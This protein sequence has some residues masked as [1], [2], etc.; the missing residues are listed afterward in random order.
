MNL[1]QARKVDLSFGGPLL[2]DKADLFIDTAE[3]IALIGRNGVG[4]S[5]LLKVIQ[6]TIRPDGGEVIY[7]PHLKLASLEQKIPEDITGAVFDVVAAGLGEV[8]GLLLKYH[9]VSQELQQ[10]DQN[11]QADCLQRLEGL[12]Q[13]LD[14][15]DGWTL[16][17]KTERTLSRLQLDAEADFSTLSGGLKRRVLLARA[18]V[19]DPELLILDEPTNHLDIQAIEW[20]ESFLPTFKG[21]VLLVSHDRR[22]LEQVTTRIIELDRG[23]LYSFPGHYGQFLQRKEEQLAAEKQQNEKF[24]KKLAQEEIWIRQGIKARRTRNMGRVRALI[25]MRKKHQA[26]RKRL[27]TVKLVAQE[28]ERSGKLVIEAENLDCTLGGKI[29]LKNFSTAIQRG[30]KI[31]L[32]GPNGC[33]KTTLLKLLLKERVPDQGDVRHGTRLEL[34]YFD[35]LREA[36]DENKTVQDSVADGRDRVLFQDRTLHVIR[37]LQDFLFTPAQVRS[38]VKALS[39][40]ERN[41]LLLARLFLKP[42]N[43]LL[44]DEPTN[45][46]DS[47]TLEL[48][49]ERLAEYA[50]TVLLVSH[51]RTFINNVVTSLFVFEGKG[52][53][54][55]Y[56]GGYDDWLRQRPEPI[57]E[58]KKKTIKEK[59]RP[60]KKQKLGL[61]FKENRELESL[62]GIIEALELAQEDLHQQLADPAFYQQSGEKIAAEQQKLT[63]L[64]QQ[65]QMHYQRWEFLEEK[66]ETA[67]S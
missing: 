63:D 10:G 20:L 27:G 6:G 67:T 24:D 28:A 13:Q 55:E 43:L 37:Y 26:R 25:E 42:A 48:L 40:G 12:Q 61:T 8:G 29:I 45:D 50:G 36:L 46:L 33:G 54:E 23:K 16:K 7:K 65:L 53:V 39:G 5:S 21:S 35:Q 38:P 56:V 52:V 64:E 17:Q 66:K 2:L 18:L 32:I 60:P 62:P 15:Q 11:Q 9:A 41:R 57:I 49:E 14:A 51:D 1:L 19:K 47:E 3:R 4:K 22:F 59:K 44:L 58:I 34:A 30:D 31:G